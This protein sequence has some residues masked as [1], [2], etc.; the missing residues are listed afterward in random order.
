MVA[1]NWIPPA[2]EL[3]KLTKVFDVGLPKWAKSFLGFSD[4]VAG[5]TSKV[6]N[7]ADGTRRLVTRRGTQFVTHTK[8]LKKIADFADAAKDGGKVTKAARTLFGVKVP[9][10]FSA[11]GDKIAD[12]GKQLDIAGAIKTK[13]LAKGLTSVAGKAATSVVG[14]TLAKAFRIAGSPVFDVAAM[15]K[16]MYDIASVTMDDKLSLIHI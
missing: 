8:D 16:D 11:V 5:T 4:D 3:Q 6:E 13:G 9:G 2:K 10:M 14:G 7:W 12:V 1:G 15:G